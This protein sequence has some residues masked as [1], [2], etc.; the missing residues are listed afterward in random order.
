[1][2]PFGAFGNVVEMQLHNGTE[3]SQLSSEFIVIYDLKKPAKGASWRYVLSVVALVG[4]EDMNMGISNSLLFY[5][6]SVVAFKLLSTIVCSCTGK[7]L[8]LG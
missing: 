7:F 4:A 1:M 3:K 2:I 8:S 5:G 6:V